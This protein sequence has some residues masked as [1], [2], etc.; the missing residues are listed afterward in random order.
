MFGVPK[1]WVIAGSWSFVVL[2]CCC[3]RRCG[4]AGP[5]EGLV[6]FGFAGARVKGHGT[7]LPDGGEC[8]ELRW[9]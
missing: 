7:H 9:S 3:S 6:V 1:V 8:R 4:K 5:N 2:I